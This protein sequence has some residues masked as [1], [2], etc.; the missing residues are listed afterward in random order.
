M[1]FYYLKKDIDISVCKLQ[2][3]EVSEVARFSL[4]ELK[5]QIGNNIL[6]EHQIY[7][8]NRY[9]KFLKNANIIKK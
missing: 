8:Y 4:D 9:F 6:E 3:F 1:R 2:D 5:R 7:F